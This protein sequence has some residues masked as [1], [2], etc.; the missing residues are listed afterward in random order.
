VVAAWRGSGALDEAVGLAGNRGPG[1]AAGSCAVSFEEAWAHV[2]PAIASFCRRAARNAADAH[3]LYQITAIRAWRG[4]AN[5]RGESAYLTWAMRIAEREAIRMAA[6]RERILR[7]EVAVD[8]LCAGEWLGAGSPQ[9]ATADTAP[10]VVSGANAGWIGAVVEQAERLGV[11]GR[12]E[13]RVVRERLADQETAWPGIAARLG[14]TP[15]ACA[16]AHC[17]AVPKLRVFLFTHHPQALGGQERIAAAFGRAL[18][19]P[20][21]LTAAEAEA[22]RFIVLARRSDYRRRGW[23]AALRG[24]CAKV[25]PQLVAGTAD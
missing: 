18:R 9:Q 13:A 11:L 24:A 14:L 20:A 12:S 15:T 17:R 23:Q 6:R 25:A 4:H 5:F 19:D 3:E 7:H 2:A 22:F 16:V 10:W 8:P 1:H 21:P